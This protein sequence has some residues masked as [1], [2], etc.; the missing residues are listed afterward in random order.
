[1]QSNTKPA[2]GAV[3]MIGVSI[4]LNNSDVQKTAV[5]Q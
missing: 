2:E 5:L 1:M 4:S 3:S